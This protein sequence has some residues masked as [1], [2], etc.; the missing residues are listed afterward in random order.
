MPAVDA[1]KALGFLKTITS[2]NCGVKR[3]KDLESGTEKNNTF[4]QNNTILPIHIGTQ[5]L[6]K[7]EVKETFFFS[8]SLMHICVNIFNLFFSYIFLFYSFFMFL[9]CFA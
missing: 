3:S 9:Y 6:L 1:I 8:F 5:A 4:L 7:V 2:Y